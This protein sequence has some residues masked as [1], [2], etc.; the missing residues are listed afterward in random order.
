MH[1]EPRPKTRTLPSASIVAM[2]P[3][4]TQ[5][6]P[7]ISTKAP[8]VFSGSL[9]Y[10]SGIR[11]E[12]A[13]VPTSPEPGTT[14]LR[15]SVKT[16]LRSPIRNRSPPPR[17]ELP[18]S[19]VADPWKP[20]SEEPKLSRIVTLGRRALM[21]SFTEGD[22]I[23]PAVEI[24]NRD[25]RSQPSPFSSRAS[26]MGRAM[27]SPTMATE[28]A[29]SAATAS[30]TDSPLKSSTS[31]TLSP[32]KRPMKVPNWAAPW[33]RGGV[34]H[35]VRWCRTAAFSAT[36]SGFA[37]G[38]PPGF[39]PPMPAKKTSSW[40]QITPLGMPVV[41]PVYTIQRSSPERPGKSRSGDEAASAAS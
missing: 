17:L 24:T 28:F 19:A 11:P 26:A 41:P 37:T 1:T 12:S 32:Q 18:D 35:I 4:S 30:H 16:L 22:V 38:S 34:R 29:F 13:S 5:R 21:R 33:M 25:E 40:R 10:P 31:T 23:A 20:V 7:S 15:S 14:A 39:P 3:S 36:S 8:A 9:W 27:A 6:T 2:S